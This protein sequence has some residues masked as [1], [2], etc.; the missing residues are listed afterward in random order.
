[1]APKTVLITGCTA[2]GAGAA[3]ASEFHRRGYT[4][5]ATSTNGSR[6]ETLSNAGV[7]TLA[8]N[9][10]S[11]SSI[12]TAVAKVSAA[13]G[14][15]LNILIN[16]AAVFDQMPLLDVDIERARK[17]YE[18]NLFGA[19]AVIQAF[20]PL[21]IKAEGKGIV[22]NVAS[23]S[24]V[25]CPAWQGIYASSKAAMVAMCNVLRIELA[26][27]GVRVVSIMS[28]GVDTAGVQASGSHGTPLPANSIYKSL[29]RYIET[30]EQ[31]IEM[32][33]MS[34]V[35]YAKQVVDGLTRETP[36]P[37]IWHGTYSWLAWMM[38]WFGWVGMTDKDQIKRS[39]LDEIE[40][41]QRG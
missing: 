25:A 7:T 2:G 27:L 39:R 35:E 11:D 23:A 21:L 1:M 30:N 24:A 13:T 22:A 4:V 34:P 41:S 14:G 3:L 29:A 19:L 26:P 5:F 16:N 12:K 20:V 40:W 33:K 36:R 10:T 31:G 8:L 32:K 6:M 9:L 28:G 37:M 17:V 38:T 15:S 18:V